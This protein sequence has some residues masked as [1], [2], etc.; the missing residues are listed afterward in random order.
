MAAVEVQTTYQGM[1]TTSSHMDFEAMDCMRCDNDNPVSA[2][3]AL[4]DLKS[5]IAQNGFNEIQSVDMM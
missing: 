2:T 4:D 1:Q 5:Y 3:S